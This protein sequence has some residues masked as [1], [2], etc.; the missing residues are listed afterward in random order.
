[1]AACTC[2]FFESHVSETLI[3]MQRPK[4]LRVGDEYVPSF[5]F[6]RD[7]DILT[8]L[9]EVVLSIL[10]STFTF[11]LT[12]KPIK[13]NVASVWFPTAGDSDTLDPELPLNVKLYKAATS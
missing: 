3:Y 2:L 6:M 5:H 13:W 8:A 7:N 10:L 11:E 12:D 9:A 1:M 4:V